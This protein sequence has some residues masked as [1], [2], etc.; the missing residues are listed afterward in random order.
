MSHYGM[1][2]EELRAGVL[3]DRPEVTSVYRGKVYLFPFAQGGEYWREADVTKLA[4]RCKSEGPMHYASLVYIEDAE[5]KTKTGGR[6]V[7][8]ALTVS[9]DGDRVL[10]HSDAYHWHVVTTPT[11]V[12]ARLSK[13]QPA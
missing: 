10:L 4:E 1:T 7:R 13:G 12:A 11:D 5:G 6:N 3:D 2:P 8:G 9:Q